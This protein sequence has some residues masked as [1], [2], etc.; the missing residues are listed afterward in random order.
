MPCSKG[1][2][3]AGGKFCPEHEHSPRTIEGVV[4]LRIAF[5]PG[6]WLRAGDTGAVVGVNYQAAAILLPDGVGRH[7]AM[8]LLNRAEIGLLAGVAKATKD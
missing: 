3:G 6:A 7:V 5:T 2:P 4:A 8:A 1:L